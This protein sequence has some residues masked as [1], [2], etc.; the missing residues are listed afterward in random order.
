MSYAIH[1]I[2]IERTGPAQNDEEV[3]AF[4][5]LDIGADGIAGEIRIELLTAER[6]KLKVLL[7]IVT[8]RLRSA[9]ARSAKKNG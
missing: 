5:K 2:E 3:V 1:R 6:E 4:G 9:L 7:D 8:A